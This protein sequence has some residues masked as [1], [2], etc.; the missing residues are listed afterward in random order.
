MA[1]GLAEAARAGLAGRARKA[2]V[3]QDERV[4]DVPPHDAITTAAMLHR[5]PNSGRCGSHGAWRVCA[6]CVWCVCGVC[7][8]HVCGMYVVCV[9]C[10]VC[11]VYVCVA[12]VCGMCGV[13][14]ACVCGVCVRW[15]CACVCVLNHI[16]SH[17]QMTTRKGRR[18]SRR[19]SGTW[20]RQG[21]VLPAPRLGTVEAKRPPGRV[22]LGGR[23]PTASTS[24]GCSSRRR[25]LPPPRPP[26]S[27]C[28]GS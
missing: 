8:W 5:T 10:V 2:A 28:S 21:G 17:K 14:V 19:C 18:V 24:G 6:A 16:K 7:V 22:S 27:L 3:V 9:V 4:G 25:P 1:S 26:R 15:V 11:V 20:A 13:C 23:K 12:C